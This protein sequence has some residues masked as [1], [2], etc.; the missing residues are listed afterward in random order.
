MV[1]LDESH[2]GTVS[3]SWLGSG[4][5]DSKTSILNVSRFTL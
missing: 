5:N 4:Y 3:L 2:M 1:D